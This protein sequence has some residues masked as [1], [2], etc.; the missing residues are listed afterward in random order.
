M[1]EFERKKL[2]DELVASGINDVFVLAAIERVPREKFIPEGLQDKAYHNIALPIGQG[3]TISQPY[4]IALM[5][6]ELKLKKGMKIL[7]IGT[8]SGYQAALL[9]AMGL[10]VFSIE[11]NYDLYI[12]T[13]KLL[14]ELG[15]QVVCRYGDGTIGWEEFAPYDGI[16]VTAG[17]PA[18][19]KSLIE[20]LKVGG[21]MVC[22]VGN[23]ESQEMYVVFKESENNIEIK[24]IPSFRFVPLIGAEGWSQ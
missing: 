5:M 7:E 18:L 14:E 3:Q 6:Q 15:Y 1:Y 11:R 2:I 17:A 20:Q 22:P 13:Q 16:I 4:T 24:K 23:L 10:R 8:G 9:K 12:R 19:P 21:R